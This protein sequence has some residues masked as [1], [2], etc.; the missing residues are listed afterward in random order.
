MIVAATVV[1]HFTTYVNRMLLAFE[2]FL[3]ERL[4]RTSSP[5]WMDGQFSQ[6]QAS[7]NKCI[8]V[9]PLILYS[10]FQNY[11][12]RSLPT[13]RGAVGIVFKDNEYYFSAFTFFAC[14]PNICK[15]MH[16]TTFTWA[17]FLCCVDE[18][19]FL[20]GHAIFHSIRKI[21]RSFDEI[22]SVANHKTSSNWAALQKK[23]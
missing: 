16:C 11:K 8:I 22:A 10:Q 13:E 7:S 14:S 19:A 3:W 20:N 21:R 17:F 12:C 1:L 9:M 15:C 4:S 23:Q 5:G 2:I 18:F 6:S